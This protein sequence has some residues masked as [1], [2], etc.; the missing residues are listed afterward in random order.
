MF[1]AR[2]RRRVRCTRRACQ[3]NDRSGNAAAGC[4]NPA[5][6]APLL[7]SR[8]GTRLPTPAPLT[9]GPRL[10]RKRY[11]QY[12]KMKRPSHTTSTKC[13]YQATPSKAKCFFGVKWP[14]SVRTQITASMVA[15]IVT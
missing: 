12:T 2:L 9:R 8:G 5:P 11:N 4:L 13:Q 6:A 3:E 15:P 14:L 7:G 1:H 10:L